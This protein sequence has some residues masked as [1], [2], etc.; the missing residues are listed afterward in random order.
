[1]CNS[2]S[3][4]KSQGAVRRVFVDMLEDEIEDVTG[5]LPAQSGIYPD[6]SAPILRHGASGGWQLAKA[7]C[8][9]PTPARFL[10]A[11]ISGRLLRVTGRIQ[12]EGQVTHLVAERVEDFSS[13]FSTLARSVAIDMDEIQYSDS[14]GAGTSAR[15]P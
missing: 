2:Y 13:M 6:Y 11:V 3:Q 9:M 15:H 1:M 8:G 4:T 5:N 12:R 10:N 14:S 7:R